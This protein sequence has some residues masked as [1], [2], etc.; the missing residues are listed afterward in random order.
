M[1]NYRTDH[2]IVGGVYLVFV[3]Y[4]LNTKQ[5]DN[6]YCCHHQKSAQQFVLAVH[7]HL[8]PP[9]EDNVDTI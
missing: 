9:S 8:E 5:P 6:Q 1:I 4:D 2:R 3:V 7:L